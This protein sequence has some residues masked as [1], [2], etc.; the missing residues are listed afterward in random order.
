V[1]T[2]GA[3]TEK[4]WLGQVV[5]LAGVFGWEPYHPWLSVHSAGLA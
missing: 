5:E 1:T 3:I 4:A 2:A